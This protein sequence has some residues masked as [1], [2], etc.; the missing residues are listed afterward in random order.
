MASPDRQVSSDAP[1]SLLFAYFAGSAVALICAAG[2]AAALGFWGLRSPLLGASAGI[3]VG[4]AVRIAARRASGTVM[5]LGG[6]LSTVSC[7]AGNFAGFATATSRA[8]SLTFVEAVVVLGSHG[9]SFLVEDA[10]TAFNLVACGVAGIVGA[11]VSRRG[12]DPQGV[13]HIMGAAGGVHFHAGDMGE[14]EGQQAKLR[15]PPADLT[16]VVDKRLPMRHQKPPDPL[17]NNDGN[18][19]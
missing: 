10:L 12:S 16:P 15:P 11:I 6:V 17:A 9:G 18:I 4:L 14:P 5:I 7:L 19:G 1:R 13:M 2:W 8:R 3:F